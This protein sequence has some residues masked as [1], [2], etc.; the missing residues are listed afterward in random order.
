MVATLP[1]KNTH[2]PT[3][4]TRTRAI[5]WRNT[6]P[7][8]ILMVETHSTV[9][10]DSRLVLWALFAVC[11]WTGNIPH[12]TSN[13]EHCIRQSTC[14]VLDTNNFGLQPG[15]RVHNKHPP[16]PMAGP[17]AQGQRSSLL[18][19]GKP[20]YIDFSEPFAGGHSRAQAQHAR[21][22][23]DWICITCGTQNFARRVT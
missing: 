15:P 3:T 6:L 13:S 20:V 10:W 21:P 4:T 5:V 7:R 1:R 23:L 18:I 9:H 14:L 22:K 12:S 8:T 16:L 17:Q 19:C 2:N 11:L